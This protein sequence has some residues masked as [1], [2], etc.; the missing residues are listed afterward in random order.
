M[1][2]HRGGLRIYCIGTPPPH[3]A[4]RQLPRR[5]VGVCPFKGPLMWIESHQ[6]L[7]NHRKTGRLARKLGVS[8]VTAI[9]HLHC[10]WWWCMDNA[11]DGNLGG[12]E[13][14]DI[15]DGAEWEGDPSEFCEA[16]CYAGFVDEEDDD[17]P[18]RLH[19]WH[20][21]AGKLIEKRQ[22]DAERKRIE[23]RKEDAPA[24][25]PVRSGN[26]QRTSIG[27]PRDGAGTVPNRT[28]PN[29]T[30]PDQGNVLRPAP[31]TGAKGGGAAAPRHAPTSPTPLRPAPK[32]KDAPPVERP[33][34]LLFEAVCD[35][36]LIDWHQ[37]TDTERGKVNAA[38]AQI[39]KAGGTPSDIPT[40]A[41]NYRATYTTPLTPMALA[42]N[43]ALTA[44]APPA[45]LN[46][47]APPSRRETLTDRNER[48]FKEAFGDEPADIPTVI[49]AAWRRN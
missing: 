26:V 24:P 38:T 5:T 1:S 46:G 39:R 13:V 4:A 17:D 42:G 8:K 31:P 40:R 48:A 34:D 35:A 32:P 22:K 45:G 49:E 29:L 3:L 11:P 30:E 33:R 6:S 21:Y 16:L 36:C 12:I 23:R 43:W 9:G 41:A 44:N 47:H 14:E 27:H 7:R 28:S 37:L 10:L 25:S 2:P 18:A 20:D 19:G 15:A